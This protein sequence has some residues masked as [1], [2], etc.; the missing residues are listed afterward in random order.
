MSKK[1][2]DKKNISLLKFNIFKFII[3]DE[4]ITTTT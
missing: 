4:L 2:S 3:N 1:M